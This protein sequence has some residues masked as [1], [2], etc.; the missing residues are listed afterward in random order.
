MIVTLSGAN[1][2]LLKTELDALVAAFLHDY[3][4]MGLERIDGEEVEYDRIRESLESLPFL[5]SKKL[6]VLRAPGANKEFIEKADKLLPEIPNS[7]DVIIV[8]PKLDKRSHYYKFLKKSTDY[9]E[10]NEL[11]EHGLSAWL[12]KKA[13][14]Y[15]ADLSSGDARYLIERVGANQQTLSQEIMKLAAYDSKITRAT[16]DLLTEPNPQS[17]IFQLLDAAF[18]GNTKHA[19]TIYQEQRASKVEPQQIIAMLAWQLHILAI[20]KTAGERSD[21]TI[22]RDAKINPFVVRKSRAIARKLQP[23]K[24]QQLIQDLAELDAKLKTVSMDADDAVQ[25]Y[26]LSI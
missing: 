16:I 10:F 15:D 11:D 5:A 3:G 20:I 4:D 18:A 1:S 21:D 17:T 12:G 6:V 26:L 19:L 13:T 14:E 7:T 22:A 9:R 23:K 25:A 2:F 8:E 24:L